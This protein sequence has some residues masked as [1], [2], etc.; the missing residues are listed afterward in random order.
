MA[1][2]ASAGAG[3]GGGGG[4]AIEFVADG[5][6]SIVIGTGVKILADGGDIPDTNTANDTDGWRAVVTAGADPWCDPIVSQQYYQQRITFRNR[7]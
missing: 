1:N 2:N 4:G 5:N 6:G 3:A 7:W